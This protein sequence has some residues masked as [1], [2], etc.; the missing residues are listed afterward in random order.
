MF[1]LFFYNRRRLLVRLLIIGGVGFIGVN[2]VYY[3]VEKYLED[4]IVVLDVFIYVGNFFSLELLI[5]KGKIEFIKGDIGDQNVVEILLCD[6][7]IDIFVNFVVESYVDCLI[8][9]LDVFIEINIMGIYLLLKVVCQ[10]WLV[11]QKRE[12][13]CFYYIFIDEVFGLLEFDDFVFF[14]FYQY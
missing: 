3:W 1:Q 4:L 9:G 6:Y 8:I 7:Q 5:S 10:V 2:F 14:E 13:Y 12:D 11:E